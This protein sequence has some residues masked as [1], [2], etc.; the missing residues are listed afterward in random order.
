MK[1]KDENEKIAENENENTGFN[2][3][4]DNEF[5]DIFKKQAEADRAAGIESV[6]NIEYCKIASNR[7][8]RPFA[9]FYYY[10]CAFLILF[11]VF[12]AFNISQIAGERLV[13][14]TPRTNYEYSYE[15]GDLKEK[16]APVFYD[17]YR[18]P[19]AVLLFFAA[20]GFILFIILAAAAALFRFAYL[21]LSGAGKKPG[22]LFFF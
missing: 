11:I 3:G 22:V 5:A 6:K 20:E 12:M 17:R 14:E 13:N 2:N 21:R 1:L 4:A 8:K 15:S 16:S 18:N 7:R 19:F 9:L 10:L